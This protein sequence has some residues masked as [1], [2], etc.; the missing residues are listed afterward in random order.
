MSSGHLVDD[1]KRPLACCACARECGWQFGSVRFKATSFL[2]FLSSLCL[3]LSR[4]RARVFVCLSVCGE[5]QGARGEGNPNGRV[6]ETLT[7]RGREKKR[8]FH[9]L[10]VCR[11]KGIGVC[12]ETPVVISE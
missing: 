7:V 5:S 6:G 11:R 8:K 3:S 9:L 2:S 4:H 10:V 1:E 12:L